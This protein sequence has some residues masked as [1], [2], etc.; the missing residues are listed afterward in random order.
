MNIIRGV[1]L[2]T[3]LYF[4]IALP[5]AILFIGF[6]YFM[7]FALAGRSLNQSIREGGNFEKRVGFFTAWIFCTTL[8]YSILL[9][10]TLTGES[11]VGI[12]LIYAP[13]VV[14]IS[15]L[16]GWLF[17]KPFKRLLIKPK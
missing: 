15:F 8:I 7:A 12:A 1:Q 5:F 6:P 16:F 2:L 9:F 3:Y 14:L 10:G 13:I 4:F 11:Q 17:S